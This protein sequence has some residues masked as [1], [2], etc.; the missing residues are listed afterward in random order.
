MERSQLNCNCTDE[1]DATLCTRCNTCDGCKNYV[2]KPSN[3]RAFEFHD[4]FTFALCSDCAPLFQGAHFAEE[5]Y[6]FPPLPAAPAAP[7]PPFVGIR[8]RRLG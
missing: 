4:L 3:M 5:D 7:P 1:W 6:F 2:I 8:Q